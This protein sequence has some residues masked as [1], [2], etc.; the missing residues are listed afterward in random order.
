MRSK[1]DKA[2]RKAVR[3]GYKY[4][5]KYG[6]CAQATFAAIADA[7]NLK[8]EEVFKALIG[9]SGG[10]ANMGKGACG[11]MAGAAAA[12]SLKFGVRREV[13]KRNPEAILK[14]K[15]HIYEMVEKVGGK[16]LEE[17]GSYLCR[18][19]QMALFGK[20]FNLRDP[21]IYEEFREIAWPE[22]CSKKVVGKA[23]GWTIDVIL[24]AEKRKPKRLKMPE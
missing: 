7:L 1:A 2:R 23:A 24:E 16:F 8:G 9:L 4:P 22:V 13:L 14:A 6:G 18:D 12:I 17:F 20:A 10:V 3:L 21:K 5:A 15:D 19:I 11:S